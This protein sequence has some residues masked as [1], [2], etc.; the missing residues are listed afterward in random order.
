MPRSSTF[1]VLSS[2]ASSAFSAPQLLR[3]RCL[4]NNLYF[5]AVLL[6][7]CA[8]RAILRQRGKLLRWLRGAS[9][10][11][12]NLCGLGKDSSITAASAENREGSVWDGQRDLYDRRTGE[13]EEEMGR[14]NEEAKSCCVLC[15][16]ELL[17]LGDKA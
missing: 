13:E 8:R 3:F 1:T 11:A 7:V 14:G 12:A 15:T 6:G 4:V 9:S 2:K 17:N 10:P 16:G 5:I